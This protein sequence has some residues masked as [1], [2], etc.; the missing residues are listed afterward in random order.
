MFKLIIIV[1][2]LT[3]IDNQN[4]PITFLYWANR[5]NRSR[6]YVENVKKPNACSIF[7]LASYG[8]S[9]N[10]RSMYSLISGKILAVITKQITNGIT[11]NLKYLCYSR[12][13]L[14]FLSSFTYEAIRRGWLW[15]PPIARWLRK[16][17]W[18]CLWMKLGILCRRWLIYLLPEHTSNLYC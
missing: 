15:K 16:A 2:L 7:M 6:K 9:L 14:N 11:K 5:Q 13:T 18:L 4:Q 12:L 10:L 1:M 17:W 3:H 8:M